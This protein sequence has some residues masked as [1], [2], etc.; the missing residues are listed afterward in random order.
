M[1]SK[2]R[3]F[4]VDVNLTHRRLKA[5]SYGNCTKTLRMMHRAGQGRWGWSSHNGKHLGIVSRSEASNQSTKPKETVKKKNPRKQ[6][7]TQRKSLKKKSARYKLLTGLRR[8][9]DACLQSHD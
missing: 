3:C 1:K 4:E 8:K 7:K 9:S 6:L 2:E 5:K